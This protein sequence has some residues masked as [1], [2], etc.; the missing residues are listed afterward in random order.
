MSSQSLDLDNPG[1]PLRRL[2]DLLYRKPTLYLSLLLIPP[3]F[4]AAALFR[5]TLFRTVSRAEPRL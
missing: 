5:I 3:P 1:G 4:R 2:S